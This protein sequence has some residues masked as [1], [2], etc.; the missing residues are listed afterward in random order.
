MLYILRF[1]AL[2]VF[3][4]LCTP[5]KLVARNVIHLSPSAEPREH[6]FTILIPDGW[7]TQGGIYRVDPS[8]AG[9]AGNSI[10]AKLDFV[11]KRDAA[12]TVMTHTF[13]DQLYMDMRRSPAA[14]MF[15][16]GSN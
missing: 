13:P 12:G 6:A 4:N 5:F 16:P 14:S 8:R 2:L 10:A 7:I 1:C 9:G 3:L 11:V 15:P